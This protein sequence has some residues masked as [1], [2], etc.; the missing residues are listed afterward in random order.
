M[1]MR[2]YINFLI[3]TVLLLSI[4]S[5]TNRQHKVIEL[6]E[7]HLEQSINNSGKLRIISVSDPDSVFGTIYFT[8]QEQKNMVHPTFRVIL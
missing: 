8:E 7:A 1:N 6:A 2:K 4:S 3:G 5:C